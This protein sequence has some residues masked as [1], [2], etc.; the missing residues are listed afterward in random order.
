VTAG[1]VSVGA[2]IVAHYGPKGPA[3]GTWL[4]TLQ[5]T[6][7]TVAGADFHPRPLAD[8]H[9]TVL[10][11]EWPVREVSVADV[12][13][14]AA[15]LADRLDVGGTI[16]FG[17]FGPGAGTFRSRGKT[18]FERSFAIR[19]GLCVVIGWPIIG[20]GLR[21]EAVEMLASLRTDMELHGFRHRYH[22]DGETDPDAYMVIGTGALDASV[23]EAI[24]KF[25]QDHPIEVGFRT[26]DISLVRYTNTELP[27]GSSVA[28]PI[29]GVDHS[30]AAQVIAMVPER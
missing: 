5:R 27:H 10:G 19:D 14:L 21:A 30:V 1:Q 11:L 22:V 29:S 16:R 24:R 17:G 18:L 9:F 28:V 15:D 6:I 3:F 12:E 2:T 8:I 26:P 13:S 25:L 4:E 7:A 23:E 20:R